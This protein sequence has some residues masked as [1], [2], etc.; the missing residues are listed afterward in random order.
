MNA[1]RHPTLLLG[2][3][4][5]TSSNSFISSLPC[6]SSFSSKSLHSQNMSK[7]S[8]CS[9]EYDENMMIKMLYESVYYPNESPDYYRKSGRIIKEMETKIPR[10]VKEV[11]HL[12]NSEYLRD[13]D[14][15]KLQSFDNG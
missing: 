8:E 11:V 9:F 5:S 1:S 10:E 3:T 13:L 12:Q 4:S 7:N 15:K 14:L 2:N 6:Y